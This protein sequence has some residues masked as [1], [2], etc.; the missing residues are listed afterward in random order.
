MIGIRSPVGTGCSGNPF[1]VGYNLCSGFHCE[2]CCSVV[3]SRRMGYGDTGCREIGT[4]WQM[5]YEFANCFAFAGNYWRAG[6]SLADE[7]DEW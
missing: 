6:W 1:A 4:G 2:G 7:T 3:H 5:S